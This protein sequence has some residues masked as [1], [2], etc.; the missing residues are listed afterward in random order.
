[1]GI[2]LILISC[3]NAT[4]CAALFHDSCCQIFDG[5][6][7]Q[8]GEIPVSKGLYCVMTLQ[9]LYTGI[10]KMKEALTMEEVH[11]RLG[12]IA[13]NTIRKMLHDGT[14]TGITLD[15]RHVTMGSCDSCDYAKA[16]F[17]DK[18]HSDLWGPSPVQ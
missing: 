7:K 2:T 14:I 9:T 5:K 8:L 1:M 11:Y 18:V 12:H 17:G 4:G 10:A 6:K 16:I 3:L 15:T 13:P